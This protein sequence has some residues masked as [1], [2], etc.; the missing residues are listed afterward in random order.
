MELEIQRT[1]Y[2]DGTN[3]VLY[4]DGKKFC[5]TIELAWHENKTGASCI[6]A[7]R[8]EL[9]AR[10]SEHFGNHVILKN[11]PGRELILI[12]PANDAIKELRGCIAPIT[13]LTAPGKGNSSRA[14]FTPLMA[15]I[16]ARFT[17]HEK[18]FVL[19]A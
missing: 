4:V 18:V 15:L 5:N 2:P 19:I 13:T 1:Y 3:G 16:Y 8:Y 12:H 6:P 11:V 17:L 9:A 10:N 7:G 14:K